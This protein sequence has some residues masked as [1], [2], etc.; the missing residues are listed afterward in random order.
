MTVPQF[1]EKNSNNS[2][3]RNPLHGRLPTFQAPKTVILCYH[4]PF[5]K[6]ILENRAHQQCDGC[7]PR[8]Y[9]LKDHPGVAIGNFGSGAPI[10]AGKMEE[11]ISW[12]VLQFI[13]IGTAASLQTKAKTGD[14]I[15]CEKA[16]RDEKTSQRFLPPAK[17]IHAPR[18]M[19]NKL[20]QQLKKGGLPFHVGSSWTT[21]NFL[22][23]T[24]EEMLQYQ[25]EGV[26]T[27]ETE[28]AALFAVAHFY[29]VDLG[30]MFTI[31]GSQQGAVWE[32]QPEDETTHR[33]LES[34]FAAALE[35]SKE[36]TTSP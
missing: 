26:L 17:Y 29:Q 8:L 4:A 14:I 10:T 2:S 27:M 31:T 19:T 36:Q 1:D 13:S 25:K 24:G 9:F 11:L 23:Q 33:G 22:R 30:A 20:Q 5:V 18:R 12:G 21:D 34:L 35:A 15:V 6:K 28:A 16:I 7:F 32:P 3:D